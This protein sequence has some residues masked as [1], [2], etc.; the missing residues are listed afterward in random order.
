MLKGYCLPLSPQGKASLIDELPWH[1]GSDSIF[2]KFRSDEEAIRERLPEPLTPAPEPIGYA[3]VTEIVSVGDKNRDMVYTNPAGTLY[4]EGGV[5]LECRYKDEP[6]IFVTAM[7][8]NQDWSMMRG[9]FQGLPKKIA[10]IYLTK[11]HPL[12]P[13]LKPFGVGTGLTGIVERL[14][15]RVL[16]ATIKIKKQGTLQDVPKLGT[17]YNIRHFPNLQPGERPSVNELVKL[18]LANQKVANIWVGDA[19]L[20]FGE[21][22]NEE[23]TRLQPRKVEGG[24]Y[25]SMGYTIMG[26]KIVHKY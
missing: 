15:D 22:E 18:D 13:A 25:F 12:N 23:L 5:V 14:G 2:V 21:S 10:R 26:S 7:W 9:W 3:Y 16:K 6:A 11:L 20:S 1:Y 4:M 8:V 19:T 24:C 17:S